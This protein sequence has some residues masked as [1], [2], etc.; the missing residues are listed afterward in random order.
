MNTLLRAIVILPFL[1]SSGC[2]LLGLND[3]GSGNSADVKKDGKKSLKDKD[4]LAEIEEE[5]EFIYNSIGKRDPFRSFL[6]FSSDSSI[7]DDLPRTP[8]QRYDVEQYRLTGIIYN[9]GR[10]RALVEDPEG[11]GHVMELGTYIGRNWGKV[12]QISSEKVTI[13]EEYK[14]RDGQLVVKQIAIPLRTEGL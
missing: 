2:D 8:L 7:F 14:T 1:M 12:S 13:T 5:E 4:T 9:V 6:S 10:P 11:V 3:G